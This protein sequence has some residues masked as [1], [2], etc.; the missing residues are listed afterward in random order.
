MILMNKKI[1]VNV[2]LKLLVLTGISLQATA[3]KKQPSMAEAQAQ[4]AKAQHMLDSIQK[5]IPASARQ[6]MPKM[7]DLKKINK[8]MN[9]SMA[10]VQTQMAAQ[11]TSRDKG[12]PKASNAAFSAVPNI[13]SAAVV[14]LAKA[15]KASAIVS[16][17]RL[18]PMLREA[19]DSMVA[20]D[21]VFTPQAHGMMEFM[22]GHPKCMGE[23][24]VCN[25]IL[26]NPNNPWA[27]NDLGIMLR[28]E[29]QYKQAAQCF[30]YAY[31]FNDTFLVIKNNLAWAVA[32]GGDL[33][34]AKKYFQEIVAILPHYDLAWEGLGIIAYQQGDIAGLFTAL[35]KQIKSVGAGGDG[36]SDEFASFCGGVM[37]E[38][39]FNTAMSGGATGGSAGGGSS[40]EALNNNTFDGNG[41]DEEGNQD[42]PPTADVEYPTYPNTFGGFFPQDIEMIPATMKLWPSFVNQIN[43]KDAAAKGRMD[44]ARTGLPRL[45]PPSYQDDQG[46]TV[47]PASSEK[48]Y[49]LF[50]GATKLFEQRVSAVYNGYDDEEEK[51]VLSVAS[52]ERSLIDDWTASLK[53]DCANDKSPGNEC[54]KSVICKIRPK[55]KGTLGMN[56]GGYSEMWTKY[57]KRLLS[58]TDWYVDATTPFIKRVHNVKWNDYM[59]AI[60]QYEVRHALLGAYARWKAVPLLTQSFYF[61]LAQEQVECITQL[62]EAAGAPANPTN[63][64]VK[65]LKT[66]PDYCDPKSGTRGGLGDVLTY[67]SNC[68]AYK[69][70]LLP[71]QQG[72]Q[73]QGQSRPYQRI[74]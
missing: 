65:K 17:Q 18:S 46:M 61:V 19:L 1:A 23:Y 12:L 29:K 36:P 58:Q 70:R 53:N 38:Q 49:N 26:K 13:D 72:S 9:T 20:Q 33:N 73:R 28:A 32:Y 48:Y 43:A 16:L 5:G 67:E 45:S 40:S 10:N 42:E 71:H 4:M 34:T 59:N 27:I 52:S 14:S 55:A 2:L 31:T 56:F 62:K 15:L 60:R 39:E 41:S 63:Q 37:N 11:K 30:A 54:Y 35:S 68:D 66:F 51:L 57:F 25:G 21:T 3:Q 7:P 50:A 8:D 64:K 24:I 69:D 74:C 47:T 44:A 6:Y 22:A